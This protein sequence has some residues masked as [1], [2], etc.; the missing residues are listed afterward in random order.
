MSDLVTGRVRLAIHGIDFE[1]LKQIAP[2][3]H[4]P[5]QQQLPPSQDGED[6]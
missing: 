5:V 4:D 1:K 2:R 6:K 3:T